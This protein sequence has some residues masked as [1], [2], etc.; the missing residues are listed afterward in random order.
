LLVGLSLMLASC[1]GSSTGSVTPPGG[2]PAGTYPIT[3]TG[4]T[5]SGGVTRTLGLTLNVQ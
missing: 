4:T 1:F 3:I 5:A 2:T